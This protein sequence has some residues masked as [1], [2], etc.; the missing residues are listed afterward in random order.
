MIA[1][2]RAAWVAAAVLPSVPLALGALWLALASVSGEVHGLWP[3]GGWRPENW[4]FLTETIG[5]RPS[6]WLVLGNSVAFAAGVAAV[7]VL[8][9]AMAA[10]A[11]SRLRFPGRGF[12]LGLVLVLH[13]FPAVSLLIAIFYVLRVLG[14]FDTLL[15]IVLVKV[16][17]DLPLGVWLLKGFF[18]DLPPELEDAARVDGARAATIFWRVA[19]P[20]V[21]P[22]L[23]ALGTLALLSAWGEFILPF[24]LI[25]SGKSWTL[26]LY[27]QSLIGDYRFAD[28]G[29]L[30]AVGLFYM[31]PVV[32]LFLGAQ[33]F[34]LNVYGGGARA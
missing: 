15:G 2:G 34:L 17:L 33:R 18:D 16:A 24:T 22:G 26:S 19:L 30:A 12:G 1:R 6:V 9:A 20:F 4:R 25:V 29:L 8:V 13:A 5:S 14:L 3:T 23:L 10:Y 21:R 31:A 28:F 7:E 11:L 32:A 27:L